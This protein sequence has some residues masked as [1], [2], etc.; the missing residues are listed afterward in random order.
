MAMRLELDHIIAYSAHADGIDGL[1]T[2]NKILTTLRDTI[3][4]QVNLTAGSICGLIVLRLHREICSP[5]LDALHYVRQ[6]TSRY[7]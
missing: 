6:P 7:I 1:R 2:A 4:E 5:V 3:N